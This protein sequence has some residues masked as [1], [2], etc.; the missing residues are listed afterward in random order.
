VCIV[1]DNYIYLRQFLLTPTTVAGVKRSS[2]SLSLSVILYM[3]VRSITQKNDSKVFKL[4][5]GNNLHISINI[6]FRSKGHRVT[7]CKIIEGDRVAGMSLHSS[8]N[9]LAFLK[10][11]VNLSVCL[12][13]FSTLF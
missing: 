13:I 6:V 5:I 9:R 4:G 1:N 3:C 7:K 11:I 10:F 8:A 2:A 12:V